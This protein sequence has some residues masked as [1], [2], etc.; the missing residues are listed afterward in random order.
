MFTT[1][2]RPSR[3]GF[4]FA[5]MWRDVLLGTVP[6]RGRCGGMAFAALDYFDA[7][8][9][10]P[11]GRELPAYD[12][13]LARLTWRRQLASVFA[14]LGYNLWRFVQMT[15][16][17]TAGSRGVAALTHRETGR[18][19]DSLAAGRPVPL[20][21]INAFDLKHLGRNHQVLAYAAELTLTHARIR[22]YDPNHPLRDD[23]V[24][25]VPREGADPLV[26]RV[27]DRRI[28]WRGMFAEK[29][30]PIPRVGSATKLEEHA[31][32]DGTV[33]LVG[34]LGLLATIGV[35]RWM[36]GRRRY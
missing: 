28:Q 24:L 6:V 7:G 22:I 29:Y 23:V 26:E 25:E 14:G 11:E 4:G 20:G 18:V 5:N 31:P 10:I 19:L 2:F 16:R 8:E 33:L 21:L 15:Y 1:D 27:G 36:F 13:A 35:L 34:A 9:P 32:G 12:S 30:A 3:H 17:P